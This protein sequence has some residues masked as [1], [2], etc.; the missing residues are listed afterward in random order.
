MFGMLNPAANVLGLADSYLGARIAQAKKDDAEAIALFTK[1]VEQEDA[2]AYDEPPS[3]WLDAREPLGAALLR[4][5]RP[6]E[7]EAVFRKD[8][9]WN[10]RSG[11]ALFGLLQCLRAQHRTYD[12]A[13]IEQQFNTAWKNADTTL[14]IEDF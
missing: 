6:A 7:A 3:W 11:R 9:E 10:V 12:V 1:A 4:A 13:W 8:L 5:G 14:T 2:L